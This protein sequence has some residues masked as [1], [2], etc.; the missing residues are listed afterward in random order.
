MDIRLKNFV[1]LSDKEIEQLSKI[2]AK[3]EIMQYIASGKPYTKKHLFDFRK[4]EKTQEKLPVLKRAYWTYAIMHKTD[5]IG[6]FVLYKFNLAKLKITPIGITKKNLKH[7]KYS[8]KN[9]NVLNILNRILI[10]TEYQGKGIGLQIYELVKKMARESIFKN[11]NIPVY[12][13]SFVLDNNI[14]SIKLQIKADFEK[15]A[16]HKDGDEFY[17]IYRWRV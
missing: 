10:D 11:V 14:P 8:K 7:T 2:T 12:L 4:D 15:Y 5:V 3:Q 6:M 17:Y 1:K 16:T 9:H 13:V